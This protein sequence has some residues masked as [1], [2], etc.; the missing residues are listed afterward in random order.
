[1]KERIKG[2]RNEK[3]ERKGGKVKHLEK[4]MTLKG[5]E[6]CKDEKKKE[7]SIYLF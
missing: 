4:G 5:G 1:M 7:F 2:T 3:E 6:R